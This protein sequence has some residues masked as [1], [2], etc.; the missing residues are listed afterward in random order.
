VG[1][2][3]S[4]LNMTELM[5]SIELLNVSL[6]RSNFEVFNPKEAPN[7][8]SIDFSL[9]IDLI[10]N[11]EDKNF[12]IIYKFIV[13]G[14]RPDEELFILEEEF[15]AIFI[16]ANPD[17]FNKTSKESQVHFCSSIIY[18][19]LRENASYTLNKAGLG[20]INLPFHFSVPEF[21]KGK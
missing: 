10:E 12:E 16:K 19:I 15:N 20:Q 2:D 4:E 5:Q 21:S 3:T 8:G 14:F 1:S 13:K 11:D 9:K 6:I 7:G 17:I 18:P